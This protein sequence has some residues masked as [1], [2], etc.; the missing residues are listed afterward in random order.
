MWFSLLHYH[1]LIHT[2]PTS[3]L[4]PN[5]TSDEADIKI[6]QQFFATNSTLGMI[7][8]YPILGEKTNPFDYNSTYVEERAKTF[9]EYVSFFSLACLFY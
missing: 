3:L 8:Q 9:D 1:A 6:E 5:E 4:D 2:F 7:I